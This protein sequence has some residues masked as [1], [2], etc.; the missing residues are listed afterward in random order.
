MSDED[1]E[2][3]RERCVPEA[4]A[5]MVKANGDCQIFAAQK[6]PCKSAKEI[7]FECGLTCVEYRFL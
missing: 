7:L 3:K 4:G 1:I 5:K 2:L 6:G